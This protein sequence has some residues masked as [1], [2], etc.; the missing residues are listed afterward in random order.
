MDANRV[1]ARR[2]F[3]EEHLSP[4]EI[5]QRLGIPVNTVR[6]WKLRDQWCNAMQ[7]SAPDAT[8][9]REAKQ[10]AE[11]EGLNDRQHLFCLHYSRSFNATRSYQK[12]YGCTYEAALRAGPA[13]LGNIGVRNEIMR[14]KQERYTQALLTESDIFQKFMDIAFADISDYLDWGREEVPVMAMFGPVKIKDADGKETPVTKIINTVRFRESN[15]VDASILSEVKQG[16]DGV[17]I[18][19][20][21]RMKAL[22]WLTDHM[23]MG[24]EEQRA[25]ID[26]LRSDIALNERKVEIDLIKAENA[27]G[28]AGDDTPDD[29]FIQ[30]LSGEAAEV[31][32]DGSEE[33]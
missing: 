21:D 31:W 15:E 27:A 4:A 11:T 9:A 7:C 28:T 18:K 2:L 1:E 16:K 12:A 32:A 3:E 22:D 10:L 17:S 8:R 19:L 30:A 26:K 33:D 14:L 23:N 24:N 6:S 5:A 13:L 25:R 20:A 29:N